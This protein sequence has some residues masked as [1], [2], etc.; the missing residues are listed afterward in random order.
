MFDSN[1]LNVGTV[2]L[3]EKNMMFGFNMGCKHDTLICISKWSIWKA[4]NNL[5]NIYIHAL[6]PYII[7]TY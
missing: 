7:T 2:N 1:T 4:R 3:N 5:Y 6:Y